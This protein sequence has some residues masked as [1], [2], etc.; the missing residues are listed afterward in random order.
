MVV[1]MFCASTYG[2]LAYFNPFKLHLVTEM[3][4]AFLWMITLYFITSTRSQALCNAR[5]SI[6]KW[7]VGSFVE[8][9]GYAGWF[10]DL[11]SQGELSTITAIG[12]HPGAQKQHDMYR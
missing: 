8:P 6:L 12:L 5:D 3:D 10:D 7:I 11:Q 1:S 4:K 9:V 2:A